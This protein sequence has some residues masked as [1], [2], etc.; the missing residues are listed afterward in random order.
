M[1]DE[2]AICD[3]ETSDDSAYERVDSVE[4]CTAVSRTL[5][6]GLHAHGV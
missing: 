4:F 3:G 1:D 6:V 2:D 5:S